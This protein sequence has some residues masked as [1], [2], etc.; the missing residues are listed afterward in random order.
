MANEIN[1]VNDTLL[2]FRPSRPKSR[3]TRRSVRTRSAG[4]TLCISSCDRRRSA[5][6]PSATRAWGRC[7]RDRPA[8]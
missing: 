1:K 3:P 2:G 5:S 8:P 7:R 6:P 4:P